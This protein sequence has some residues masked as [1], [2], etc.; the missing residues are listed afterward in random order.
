MSGCNCTGRCRI[1]GSCSGGPYRTNQQEE[2]ME[3]IPHKCPVCD[4]EGQRL[5]SP[6]TQ[7]IKYENCRA[8]HGTGVVWGW[9]TSEPQ[10]PTIQPSPHW[11]IYPY[12]PGS[13]SIT[14]KSG[15]YVTHGEYDPNDP[16]L[17]ITY[18]ENLPDGS[19]SYTA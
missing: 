12:P 5:V 19:W 6:G 17:S 9:K 8:C 18:I 11:G 1:T 16:D 15:P 3:Q 13:G 2:I 4:G 14:V 7:N 10:Y